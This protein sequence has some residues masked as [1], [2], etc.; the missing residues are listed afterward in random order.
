VRVTASRTV[1]QVPS[2]LTFVDSQG[3]TS[4]ITLAGQVPGTMFTGTFTVDASIAEGVGHFELPLGSLVA[5]QNSGNEIT[6]GREAKIDRT[7][8]YSVSNVAVQ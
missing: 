4:S 7:A 2:P 8:P 1:D 6:Q 5:G 3:G